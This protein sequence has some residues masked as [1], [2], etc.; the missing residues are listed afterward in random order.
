MLLARFP[1][2]ASGGEPVHR[3]GIMLR[4]FDRLPVTVA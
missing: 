2:L 3:G 4:G 1:R